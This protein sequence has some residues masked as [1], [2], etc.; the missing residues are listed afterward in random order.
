MLY[1]NSNLMLASCSIAGAKWAL[2]ILAAFLF[3]KEKKWLFIKQIGFTCF[4]GS[5]LLIPYCL[6]SFIRSVPNS[7]L[8]SLIIAVLTMIFLYYQSV[9]KTNITIKWF[10][11]WIACLAT[12]ISLQL[13]VIFKIF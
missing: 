4:V 11:G 8:Y 6:F 1:V 2:Q 13:F 5:F 12:A 9:R 10:W 7:F 3:L